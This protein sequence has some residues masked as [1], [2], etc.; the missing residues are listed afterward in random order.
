MGQRVSLASPRNLSLCYLGKV[1]SQVSFAEHE[2]NHTNPISVN[3][4]IGIVH[5]MVYGPHE[6]RKL[7]IFRS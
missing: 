1:S 6:R 3:Q 2:K 5:L 7:S 4:R